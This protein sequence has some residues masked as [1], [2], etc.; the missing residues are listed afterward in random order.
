M[1]DGVV[2]STRAVLTVVSDGCFYVGI[3]LLCFA[4]YRFVES[5]GF[6]KTVSFF[7]YKRRL[8]YKEPGAKPMAF[9]DF[10]EARYGRIRFDVVVFVAAMG[11][12]GISLVIAVCL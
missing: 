3:L 2:S 5:L 1:A 7:F 12:L 6:F 4:L 10:C 11:L 8:E 9:H